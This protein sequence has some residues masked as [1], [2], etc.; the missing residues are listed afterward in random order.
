MLVI[1]VHV[2]E[3]D[4]GF[5]VTCPDAPA[6]R[7]TIGSLW[8]ACTVRHALAQQA[9]VP[10]DLVWL[11][12]R[13]H[14]G[15]VTVVSDVHPLH[16]VAFHSVVHPAHRASRPSALVFEHALTALRHEADHA[17]KQNRLHAQVTFILSFIDGTKMALP[18]D[19]GYL[20]R[21]VV[22]EIR[23]TADLSAWVRTRL[24]GLP[25]SEAHWA[26]PIIGLQVGIF[27][28]EAPT[29]PRYR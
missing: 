10:D 5:E 24:T 12:I 23:E 28:P 6:V 14:S 16:W 13:A 17:L 11:Q 19:G 21:D 1:K 4:G 8:D 29:T 7:H 26:T 3:V 9:G 2:E 18:R 20:L 25:T 15:A 27:G 22:E